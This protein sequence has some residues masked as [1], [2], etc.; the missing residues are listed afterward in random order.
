MVPTSANICIAVSQTARSSDD[1]RAMKPRKIDIAATD[2]SAT[3]RIEA[4]AN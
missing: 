3:G 2:G 1:F 4:P